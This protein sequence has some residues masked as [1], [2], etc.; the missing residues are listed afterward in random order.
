M[1]EKN[2]KCRK[3]TQ[4]SDA[5]PMSLCVHS[6]Q[7]CLKE[8]DKE[9]EGVGGA[10]RKERQRKGMYKSIKSNMHIICQRERGRILSLR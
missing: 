10:G 5:L 6:R 9:R 8:K 2:Q 7:L 4:G 3:K 1:K